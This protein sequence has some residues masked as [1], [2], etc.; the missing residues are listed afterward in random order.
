[1]SVS[2]YCDELKVEV[3]IL[4]GSDPSPSAV[5][6]MRKRIDTELFLEEISGAERELLIDLLTKDHMVSL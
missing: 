2:A 1:M 5:D 3:E 4:N 6:G